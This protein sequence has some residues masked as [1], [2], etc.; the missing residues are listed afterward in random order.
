[1][2]KILKN[3]LISLAVLVGTYIFSMTVS[4]IL[5]S[6][7]FNEV[8]YKLEEVYYIANIIPSFYALAGYWDSKQKIR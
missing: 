7:F 2:K 1:M 4:F 3:I 6:Y 8:W 5:N